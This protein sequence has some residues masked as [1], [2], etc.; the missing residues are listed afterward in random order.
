MSIVIGLTGG[1]GSGKSFVAGVLEEIGIPVY[2]ADDRA[3]AIMNKKEVVQEVQ[4]LF[5]TNVIAEN[6]LLDRAMI[7]SL[8]FNNNE[9]LNALNSIVHPLVKKDYEEW[10]NE[11][12]DCL[13]VV[14]ETALLFENQLENNFNYIVL[15]TA[16][17][18]IR[19]KR[20]VERDNVSESDVVKII[21]NQLSDD[22]KARKSHYVINNINKEI[23]KKEVIAIIDG[24]KS[25]N[26]LN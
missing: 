8:V 22:K 1:I 24:I 18:E 17:E 4:N 23:V 9:Q 15:V 13:I 12:R 11:H 14:K 21:K 16:P 10:L 6:G 7:R 3:K 19:I 20:V 25:K 26:N 2:I 5:E